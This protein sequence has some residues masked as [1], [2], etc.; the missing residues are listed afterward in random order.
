MTD[1]KR[2]TELDAADIAKIIG[3]ICGLIAIAFA[4]WHLGSWIHWE[5]LTKP[6]VLDAMCEVIDPATFNDPTI[7]HRE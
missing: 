2:K 4:M 5:Y 7:C 6:H 3:T 1:N